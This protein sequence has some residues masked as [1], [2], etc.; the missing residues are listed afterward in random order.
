MRYGSVRLMAGVVLAAGVLGASAVDAAAQSRLRFT[1]SP[2]DGFYLGVHAGY[3]WGDNDAVEDPGNPV[4]YNGAGNSW[5][6]SVDGALAGVHAGLNWE[7][8]RLVMGV[9][10]SFGYLAIEGDAPDPGSP[11]LDTVAA[12]G[13]GLYGDVTGR[14]GFAPGNMLYYMEGGVA[15]AAL[16]WSVKDSCTTGACNATTVNAVNDDLESGWTAG[17]GIAW[18]FTQH[19]SLRVEYAYYDFGETRMAGSS[20]ANTFRWEQDITL[21]TVAAGVSFMF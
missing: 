20:G 4:A 8:N 12:Q 14:I 19:T 6:Y 15:F 17:V 18:A 9:E 13:D 16:D 21:H 2:W 10:A 7:S 5:G 3:G 11:G 1:P